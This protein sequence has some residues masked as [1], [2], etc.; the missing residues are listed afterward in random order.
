MNFDQIVFDL[1]GAL[2]NEDIKTLSGM[3][4]NEV[5]SLHHGWG[6]SIRNQYGLWD[7]TNPIN[8]TTHPDDVSNDIMVAVWRKVL[9][10]A[11]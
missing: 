8:A 10:I 7:S 5:R 4:E 11:S 6:M 1:Y 9:E 2:S 3:T